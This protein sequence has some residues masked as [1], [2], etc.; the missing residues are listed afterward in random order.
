MESKI[1]VFQPHTHKVMRFGI[2]GNAEMKKVFITSEQRCGTN[3]AASFHVLWSELRS[4]RKRNAPD[5]LPEIFS[6]FSRLQLQISLRSSMVNSTVN[7]FAAISQDKVCAASDVL[8]NKDGVRRPT[9]SSRNF[10]AS[11]SF[12]YRLFFK[13]FEFLQQSVLFPGHR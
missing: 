7:P 11:F 8:R 4:L 3:F 5:F 12:P 1:P 9:A 10:S 13:G 6:G 2:A